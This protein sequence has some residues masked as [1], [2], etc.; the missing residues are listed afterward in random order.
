MPSGLGAR[1]SI[2]EL[3]R[4]G[5]IA[6]SARYSSSKEFLELFG[7]ATWATALK[8]AVARSHGGEPSAQD[9]TRQLTGPPR[10]SEAADRPASTPRPTSGR[11]AQHHLQDYA[12]L[13]GRVGAPRSQDAYEAL[14]ERP[15]PVGRKLVRSIRLQSPISQMKSNDAV[16]TVAFATKVPISVSSEPK[17]RRLQP[18]S[19]ARPRSCFRWYR[20]PPA[21]RL[22]H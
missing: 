4:R 19:I 1:E 10:Y 14:R 2:S 7:G 5:G 17:S 18:E 16:P 22:R 8:E 21:T 13:M 6:Q 3:C 15:E 12:D 9:R 20:S 11:G